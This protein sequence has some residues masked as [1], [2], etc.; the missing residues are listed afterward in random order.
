MK[1]VR[2]TTII[3]LALLLLCGQIALAQRVTKFVDPRIGSEGLGRVFIGPSCPYGMCKPGP[4]CGTGNN[5]GWAPMGSNN[6]DKAPVSGFSQTHV[7]GTGGGPKYGN[8]LAAISLGQS[9]SSAVT[10]H[11]TSEHVS[12]GLYSATFS[13]GLSVSITTAERAA[14]YR[15]HDIREGLKP[16][17]VFDLD[18]FLGR[19]PVPKAREAQQFEGAAQRQL[20]DSICCGWQCISGGWNNGAPYIVYFYSVSHRVESEVLMKVGISFVSEE[21]A[22]KNLEEDI[23]HWNFEKTKLECIAK[24][25]KELCKVKLADDTPDSLKRMFY[26][27]LYHTMLMPVDRTHDNGLYD[28]YYAIWDTYRTSTPLITLLNPERQTQM[29]RSLLDIYQ[30]DGYMPDARSGNSNGRTQ[31]GSNADIVIADALAKGLDIDYDLAL[32]AMMKDAEVVPADDE[33]EGRGG[34]MDY[35]ALGFIPYGTARAGTR[36]VEYSFCDWAIAQ[37][38]KHLGKKTIHDTYLRRSNNWRN[39]WR[40]DYEQDGVRGFIMPRSREHEWLDSVP[41][42]HSRLQHRVFEYT[43]DV[44]YEGPW[45]CA[46]WDCHFYEASSWEYSFSVPHDIPGLIDA[47]GGAEAFERRL[48]TFFEHG[49]YNVANEPSFLTPMLYHWIGKPEKSQARIRQIIEANYTDRSDGLPGNDDSGSMSSWLAFHLL[50]LYPIAGHDYYL[51][52]RPYVDAAIT[53]PN[54]KALSIKARRSDKDAVTFNGTPLTDWRITHAQL[55]CGGELIVDYSDRQPQLADIPRIV[56]SRQQAPSE[57]LVTYKLHGQT[58]RFAID[59]HRHEQ[60]I[61]L[62]Y[63]IQRNLRW[64]TGSYTM[65]NAAL[66]HANSISYAQP[67]DGQHLLL[68]DN[69]LFLMMSRDTLRQLKRTGHCTWCNTHW[70]VVPSEDATLIH[71]KDTDEGAE[72]WVLDNEELPLI[73]SM[74]NNPVEINWTI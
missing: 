34:L 55:L 58:R 15:I 28:D 64:W 72:M 60:G 27:A 11:R 8:V 32:A 47:C 45:Y 7:S 20:N 57:Y 3:I 19:N 59:I 54:G 56:P 9:E 52:H 26:T 24:W 70:V 16:R 6:E 35:N 41:F 61:T 62:T 53:L 10:L 67:L 21:K 5:A 22:R 1:Q 40:P 18:H 44:S 23:P 68:P 74:Q 69:E 17:W 51:I 43:P 33:A 48:D 50:G 63:G 37:V 31:G 12:A 13:E 30:Q 71:L 36:T 66:E 14:F 73:M 49:Y 38:A 39:L 2:H 29:V 46:W 65:T 4:D 42:G 25:E